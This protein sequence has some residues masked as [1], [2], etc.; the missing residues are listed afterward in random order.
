MPCSA[1]QIHGHTGS[2]DA[3]GCTRDGNDAALARLAVGAAEALVADAF[4]RA[5]HI[6][7]ADRPRE[8]FLHAGPH[9]TQDQVTLIRLADYR[10]AAVRRLALQTVDQLECLIGIVVDDN[11]A[12]V[13]IGLCDYVREKLVA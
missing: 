4:Q 5:D 3:A 10:N 9:R 7:D 11:N 2:A 6:F 1:A 8:E 13:G 12:N